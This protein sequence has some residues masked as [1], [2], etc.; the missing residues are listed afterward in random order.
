M[1]TLTIRE[2]DAEITIAILPAL[3]LPLLTSLR[4]D[5]KCSILLIST[6]RTVLPNAPLLR[7]LWLDRREEQFE[8][9]NSEEYIAMLHTVL[10]R[11]PPLELLVLPDMDREHRD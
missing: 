2:E 10:E 3:R 1:L 11:R 8:W 5:A 7:R 4:V 6:L 9:W